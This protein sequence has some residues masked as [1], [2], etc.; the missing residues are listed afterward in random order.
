MKQSKRNMHC[1]SCGILQFFL[2]MLIVSKSEAQITFSCQGNSDETINE[3]FLRSKMYRIAND[4]CR[5]KCAW[6]PSVAQLF[7]WKCGTCN[8]KI[9]PT[10]S[11][12][13]TS[14]APARNPVKTPSI[15]TPVTFPVQQPVSPPSTPT[16]IKKCGGAVNTGGS[17]ANATC[18]SDLW[19][20]TQDMNMHC[21]AYGGNTDPCALHN[22]NDMNDGLFKSPSKCDR[23][24]FYLWDEVSSICSRET[25]QHDSS[26]KVY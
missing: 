9:S 26:L 10:M 12:P 22:N 13:V 21:Y 11:S 14:V 23:D 19:T 7:G 25:M 1:M 17:S 5:E 20:P 3:C 6:V 16:G 4:E 2:C 18:L 8:R 24:T 15:Q